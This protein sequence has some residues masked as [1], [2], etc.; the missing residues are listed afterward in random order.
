MSKAEDGSSS[1]QV[2]ASYV[3]YCVPALE[4]KS[5]FNKVIS[6]GEFLLDVSTGSSTPHRAVTSRE[7]H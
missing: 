7:R 1:K 5:T 2:V 6:I 4:R 3:T